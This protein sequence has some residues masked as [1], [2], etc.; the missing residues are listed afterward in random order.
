MLTTV[1]IL[2]SYTL[3]TPRFPSP[4]YTDRSTSHAMHGISFSVLSI[5]GTLFACLLKYCKRAVTITVV[6][7]R[8]MDATSYRVFRTFARTGSNHF[9]RLAL[10][11]S[12]VQ[13]SWLQHLLHKGDDVARRQC[14]DSVKISV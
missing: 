11:H 7:V 12:T 14:S 2:L 1:R 3:R 4:V 9:L 8:D 10:C 6:L 5:S 13:F